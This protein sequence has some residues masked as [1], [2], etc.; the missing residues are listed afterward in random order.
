MDLSYET[1][2]CLQE[3]CERTSL[4]LRAK[5]I[6][7][8]MQHQNFNPHKGKIFKIA[9]EIIRFIMNGYTPKKLF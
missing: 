6:G 8:L 4:L 2:K 1:A 5:V 7:S 9:D 3:G